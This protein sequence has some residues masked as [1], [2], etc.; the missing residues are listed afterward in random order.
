MLNDIQ[1]LAWSEAFPLGRV[2]VTYL[3]IRPL[4]IVLV[5][6][7]SDMF[8]GGRLRLGRTAVEVD[9]G[10]GYERP[11]LSLLTRA[12]TSMDVGTFNGGGGNGLRRSCATD[13][14]I[15]KEA[16]A[17]L[18]LAFQAQAKDIVGKRPLNSQVSA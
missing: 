18:A 8:C 14:A 13:M 10:V 3:Y 2:P 11:L 6:D 9:E 5:G 4:T 16:V 7:G 17:L 15:R 1:A 12:A